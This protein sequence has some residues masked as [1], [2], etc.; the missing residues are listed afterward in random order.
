[1]KVRNPSIP[2]TSDDPKALVKAVQALKES[3]EIAQ[4]LRGDPLDSFVRLRELQDLGILRNPGGDAGVVTDPKDH[5]ALT[6][7]LDDDH[8]QYFNQARGDARYSQLGHAH[9]AADITSGTL[10][11]AR[12]PALTGDV[13]SAA[14]SVATTI[15]GGVVTNAKLANMAANTIKGNNTASAAAPVDLTAAQ[16]RTLLGLATV[17]T[18]GSAADLTGTLSDNLLSSNIPRK[19]EANVFQSSG[20]GGAQTFSGPADGRIWLKSTLAATNE[21]YWGIAAESTGNLSIFTGSDAESGVANAITISRS[22]TS[23][24]GINMQANV[25]ASQ[26]EAEGYRWV[27]DGAYYIWNTD[28]YSYGSWR[29]GGSRGGYV[30]LVLDDGGKCPTFMSNNSA[31]GIYEQGISAWHYYCQ[32]GLFRVGSSYKPY[33]DG[34]P[35]AMLHYIG[36]Q[37]SG[38]ITVST[39]GPSGTPA[40]GDI[41]IQREA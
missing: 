3:M 27:R 13:T 9:S 35:G 15:A 4:R 12:M 8:T 14:G 34:G 41:W 25:Q 6:G 10:A 7:L 28:G 11:A 1:M 2:A 17:A 18:S 32:S 38:R 40:D 39:S 23:V 29:I 26:F 19:N 22:G 33:F 20:A 5:G 24:T 21:K 36:G 16:V 30:G 37:T 31:A